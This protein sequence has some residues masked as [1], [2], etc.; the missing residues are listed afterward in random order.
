MAAERWSLG[1]LAAVRDYVRDMGGGL[2]ALG[3]EDS[4]GPGGFYGTTFEEALPVRCDLEK[5]TLPS[6]ALVAVPPPVA[7]ATAHRTL[8][9][10]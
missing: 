10:S 7:R 5:K 9:L 2:L 3:G 1:Q 4:F 6:L 8:L